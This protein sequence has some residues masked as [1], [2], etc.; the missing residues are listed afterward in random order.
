MNVKTALF[1]TSIDTRSVLWKV[2][3]KNCCLTRQLVSVRSIFVEMFTEKYRPCQDPRDIGV[4]STY[5]T[6]IKKI[7]ELDIIQTRREALKVGTIESF[8]AQVRSIF[9]RE[10]L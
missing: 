7:R 10:V 6:Q 5:H 1:P 3:L 9:I 2:T 8:Q 4:I